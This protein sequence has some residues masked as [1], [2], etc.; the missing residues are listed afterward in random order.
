MKRVLFASG[1]CLAMLLSAVFVFMPSGLAKTILPGPQKENVIES[2]LKM[3]APA[4]PNPLE[5][6]QERDESFY[7]PQRPPS[8]DAPI[9]DLIDYWTNQSAQYRGSL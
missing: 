2:L 8:D 7:D 3:P 9:D 4:P 1:L 5:P 6:N